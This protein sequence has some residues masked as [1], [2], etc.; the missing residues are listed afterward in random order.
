MRSALGY[1]LITRL[2][3]QCREMVRRPARLIYLLLMV[4][5]FAVVLLGGGGTGSASLERRGHPA[6]ERGFDGLG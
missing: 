4:A 3:A 1:L 5:L 6:R 2:K